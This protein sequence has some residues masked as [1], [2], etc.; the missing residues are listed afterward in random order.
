[1]KSFVCPDLDWLKEKLHTDNY[2]LIVIC[3]MEFNPYQ[4]Q[5]GSDFLRWVANLIN[6]ELR[7]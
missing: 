5:T 7:N 4:R 2:V 6:W 1:M 3:C